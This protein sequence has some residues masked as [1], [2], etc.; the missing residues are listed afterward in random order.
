MD[1]ATIPAYVKD[2]RRLAVVSDSELTEG[3]DF[4]KDSVLHMLG[5]GSDNHTY[6]MGLTNVVTTSRSGQLTIDLIDRDAN[7]K[8]LPRANVLYYLSG[9]ANLLDSP[10]GSAPASSCFGRPAVPLPLPT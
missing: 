3:T 2:T 10:G 4:Y 8:N 6:G 9:K 5:S 7:D 1:S